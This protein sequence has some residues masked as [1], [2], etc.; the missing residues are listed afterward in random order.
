MSMAKIKVLMIGA[1]REVQGGISAVVNSFYEVKMDEIVK[2]KYISSMR[3]GSYIKKLAVAF[4]SYIQFLMCISN[5][6]IVHIH[7]AAHASYTRK[8]I[9]VKISKIFGKKIIIHQH[10]GE[11]DNYFNNEISESK[12]K[13]IIKVFGMADRVIVLSKEW[14]D[15]FGKSVCNS[16]KIIIVHNGVAHIS[17]NNKSYMDNN[18]LVLGRLGKRK[19]TYDLLK[20]IPKI[21]EIVPKAKFYMGGDGDIAQC[22]SIAQQNGILDNIEFLGWVSGEDKKR[23]LEESSIFILPTYNEGM[24]MAILD[25]MSYGLAV[26]STNAGG[27]PQIINSGVNGIRFEA[28]DIEAIILNITKLLMD[29]NY[30]RQLGMAGKETIQSKFNVRE[31]VEKIVKVYEELMGK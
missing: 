14:A 23:Y 7:M 12:R 28:G 3:D 21:L 22:K 2:L 16:E 25:A 9:F 31:S 1:G 17:K 18:I 10:S 5:Y 20:A 8:R 26:I 11:F 4:L 29:T 6:D 30:K 27:I 15:F 19:G 24:P 13:D